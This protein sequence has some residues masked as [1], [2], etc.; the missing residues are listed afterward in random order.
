MRFL[1]IAPVFQPKKTCHV[2]RHMRI[3]VECRMPDLQKDV[4]LREVPSPRV[5]KVPH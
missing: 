3:Y 2:C 1:Y 4:V 5:P